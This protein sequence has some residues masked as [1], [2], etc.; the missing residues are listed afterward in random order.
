MSK[1]PFLLKKSKKHSLLSTS[2]KLNKNLNSLSTCQSKD[3]KKSNKP[4]ILKDSGLLTLNSEEKN[5]IIFPSTLKKFMTKRKMTLSP[6]EISKLDAIGKKNI[7]SFDDRLNSSRKKSLNM[8][9]MASLNSK[10]SLRWD[11]YSFTNKQ[12]I[13]KQ[14]LKNIKKKIK[15]KDL[16]KSIKEY[17]N[18]KIYES[19]A[20]TKK[21]K[22]KKKT[23][24]SVKSDT[25]REDVFGN[26]IIRG[27]R[28]HR[29]SFSYKGD[30]KV[31]ENWKKF[32]RDNTIKPDHSKKFFEDDDEKKKCRVF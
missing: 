19:E 20:K 29:V 18:S 21:S 10:G 7:V 6:N 17:R 22:S 30:L 16:I 3:E 28:N 12:S 2:P 4:Q 13:S 14:E 32:N 1:N 11:D 15:D 25:S 8:T 5:P 9:S 31:V 23:A 26:K 27:G 24:I